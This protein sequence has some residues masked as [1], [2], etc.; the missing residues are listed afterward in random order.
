MIYTGTLND[1]EK[2]CSS[3]KIYIVLNYA[4]AVQSTWYYLSLIISI[5]ISSVFIYFYKYLKRDNIQVKFNANNQA[6][7]Y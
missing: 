4:I 1:Y 5:S 2:L 6:T 3:C 7:T